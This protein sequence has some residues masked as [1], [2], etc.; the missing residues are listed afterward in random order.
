MTHFYEQ[1]AVSFDVDIT[2]VVVLY[3]IFG[4]LIIIAVL[5]SELAGAYRFMLKRLRLLT[6]MVQT[7]HSQLHI[8]QY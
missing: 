3:T 5:I 7:V 2:L 1:E 8:G 4:L 6:K